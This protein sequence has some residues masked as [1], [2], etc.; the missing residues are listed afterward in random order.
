MVKGRG[1]ILRK[2]GQMVK[3]G[4]IVKKQRQM[5]KGRGGGNCKKQG[6]MVN[7]GEATG[8]GMGEIVKNRS[9]L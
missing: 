8:E 1:E 2:Q 7:G 4:R 3:G 5:V 9:E 6:R